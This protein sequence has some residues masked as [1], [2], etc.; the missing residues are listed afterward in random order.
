MADFTV[1][2]CIL[3]IYLYKFIYINRFIFLFIYLSLGSEGGITWHG[4][5]NFTTGRLTCFGCGT[6]AKM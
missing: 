1:P 6:F 5:S 4:Y 3:A 2:T